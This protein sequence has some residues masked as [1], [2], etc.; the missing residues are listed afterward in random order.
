MS[1]KYF[2]TPQTSPTKRPSYTHILSLHFKNLFN[3]SGHERRREYWLYAITIWVLYI[4]L[5]IAASLIWGYSNLDE[6]IQLASQED[7]TDEEIVE[8]GFTVLRLILT[9]VILALICGFLTLAAT[10][11]RLHD[12]NFSGF[13][14]IFLI[15]IPVVVFILSLIPTNYY[16]NYR[17]EDGAIFP[18]A[19]DAPEHN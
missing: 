2:N 18:E 9:S 8:A 11:R 16:N 3:F 12:A 1:Q 10:V 17:R 13:F 15:F 14:A 5:Q 7:V 4:V 19:D 6:F